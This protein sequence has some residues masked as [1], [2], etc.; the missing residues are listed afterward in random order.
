MTTIPRN[1]AIAIVLLL[2]STSTVD[3]FSTPL[4]VTTGRPSTLLLSTVLEE[5]STATATKIAIV[6]PQE[7]E[8]LVEPEIKAWNDDGFIFGM[9][10]SGLERPRGKIAQVVV[11]GDTLG[12]TNNQR[13]IV[14]S[15]LAGHIGIFAFS[16]SQMLQANQGIFGAMSAGG[17]HA[18]MFGATVVQALLVTLTSWTMA[19]LGSGVLHWSVDNYGNGKTPVM[20][21]LIAGFQGHHSAP[22]TITERDFENNVHKLCIPFGVQV[23]L[24]MKL[25][26]GLG[27]AATLFWTVFCVFEIMSQE[28][29]K[30]SHASKPNAGPFWNGLQNIGMAISRKDHSKH[31]VAPYDG[32]Y[33]IV[34]GRCNKMLDGSGFFRRLEHIV[35]KLNGVES[36]SWKLDAKLR[37]RTLRGDYG[38]PVKGH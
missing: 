1:T 15:T 27:P 3:G 20:G 31:H 24:A 11:E 6:K 33:C 35:Y 5:P 36:N 2:G 13:A 30:M 19:D 29:H 22:W 17:N 8:I 9:E 12:S 37:E 21:P 28:F 18:L 34:S 32:N 4:S 23:V 14:W 16:F 10:G 38:L 26:F 7:D 25:V